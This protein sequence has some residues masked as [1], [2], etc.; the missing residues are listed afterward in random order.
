MIL[1]SL[2]IAIEPIALLINVGCCMANIPDLFKLLIYLVLLDHLL[3]MTLTLLGT[4]TD[5]F[6]TIKI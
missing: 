3:H 6:M 1:E 2:L 4:S 5:E